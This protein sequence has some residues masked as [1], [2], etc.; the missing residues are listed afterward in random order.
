MPPE[1]VVIPEDALSERF[2]AATG[3]GGV[4]ALFGGT[5]FPWMRRLSLERNRLGPDGLAALAGIFAWQ[6]IT[7]VQSAK[8]TPDETIEG[9]KEDIEWAKRLLRRG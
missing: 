5:E 4:R 7:R 2:L 9:V 8:F 1:D 6:G 3:P